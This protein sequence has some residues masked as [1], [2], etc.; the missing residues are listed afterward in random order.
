MC[1]RPSVPTFADSASSGLPPWQLADVLSI[2]D[3]H[4]YPSVPFVL[5]WS[6]LNAL[7]CECVVLASDV[8]P[9]REVMTDGV[10]GLLRDF[11]DEDGLSAAA[12]EVLRDPATSRPLGRAGRALIEERYAVD[13]TLPH[14]VALL[15]RV[16]G[17]KT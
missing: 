11:F 12:L 4:V 5:S 14:L 8:P 15:T 3:L 6:L 17:R 2:S 10:N 16:A 13:V 7:A 9:V 1:S